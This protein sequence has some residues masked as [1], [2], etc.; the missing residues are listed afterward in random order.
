MSGMRLDPTAVTPAVRRL[1]VAAPLLLLPTVALTIV[2]AHHPAVFL[3][4]RRDPQALRAGQWWRVI[5]PVLVQPDR[6]VTTAAVFAIVLAVLAVGERIFGIGRT[7]A[8]YV[9]GALIGH[10]IGHLWQPLGAGCSVAGCGVVGGLAVW[11]LRRRSPP[12]RFGAGA[13]LLVAV[14]GVILR[15]IH[16]PPALAGALAALALSPRLPAAS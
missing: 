9:V 1:P 10:L 5:S 7:A 6:A 3:A 8:L 12:A 2:N 13:M 4:L 14:A 16:G 15:D 11:L